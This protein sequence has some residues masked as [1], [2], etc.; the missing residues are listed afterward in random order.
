MGAP[1]AE[2]EKC[3]ADQL[4]AVKALIAVGGGLAT[5]RGHVRM[6]SIRI[7]HPKAMGVHRPTA[8]PRRVSE[9]NGVEGAG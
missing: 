6:G 3:T 4:A 9:E 8:H 2:H 1:P 7:A 5:I